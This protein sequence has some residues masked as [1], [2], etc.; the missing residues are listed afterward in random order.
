[1]SDIDECIRKMLYESGMKHEFS[2]GPPETS[3]VI[4]KTDVTSVEEF[5]IK[6]K[7]GTKPWKVFSDSF[8]IQGFTIAYGSFFKKTYENIDDEEDDYD[9]KQRL[10]IEFN[11]YLKSIDNTLTTYPLPCCWSDEAN[12]NM[13]VGFSVC[14]LLWTDCRYYIAETEDRRYLKSADDKWF[15]KRDNK[16]KMIKELE[17]EY[18]RYK[19]PKDFPAQYIHTRFKTL[20]EITDTLYLKNY[21][22]EWSFLN[23]L[24]NKEIKDITQ[25]IIQIT[26]K[27]PEWVFLPNDCYF[28][29]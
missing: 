17:S 24:Y 26:N 11:E 21:D 6:N 12:V 18:S 15:I 23:T 10:N 1:M 7:L 28:C 3:S 27:E 22:L 14:P 25:L 19:L 5:F 29:T 9:E 2:Y 4:D 16:E 8:G 20:P 13:F